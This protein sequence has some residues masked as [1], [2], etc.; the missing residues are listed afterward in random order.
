MSSYL[1]IG[2]SGSGALVIQSGGKVLSNSGNIGFYTSSTGA[3]TVADSG[4]KW[5]NTLQLYA[6]VHGNA[7][8]NIQAGGL[9][10]NTN[11]YIGSSA[12]SMGNVIE[13]VQ[14]LSG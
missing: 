6:G 1:N 5:I 12:S 14:T 3:V 11:G 4:S 2:E 7:T 8:L 9:V 13:R 10:S